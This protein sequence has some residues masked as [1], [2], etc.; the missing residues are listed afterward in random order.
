MKVNLNSSF[1]SGPGVYMPTNPPFKKKDR[2]EKRNSTKCGSS[3]VGWNKLDVPTYTNG[4]EPKE[5]FKLTFIL[6]KCLFNL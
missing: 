5:E 4:P 6:G 2:K 1:G 3:Q